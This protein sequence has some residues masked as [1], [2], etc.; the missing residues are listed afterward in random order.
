M[1]KRILR[2]IIY[3]GDEELVDAYENNSLKHTQQSHGHPRWFN[4]PK[5]EGKEI[6]ITGV[7]LTGEDG[8]FQAIEK[9]NKE[10]AHQ[11]QNTKEIT[12]KIPSLIEPILNQ[13]NK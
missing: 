13:L 8:L 5:I 2:I 10:I 9:H 7:T 12:L 1:N 4:V 11:F 6:F 3:E